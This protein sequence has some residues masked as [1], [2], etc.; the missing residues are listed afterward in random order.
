MA[1]DD[2]R[3]PD[4]KTAEDAWSHLLRETRMPLKD[5][6]LCRLVFFAGMSAALS[7]AYHYGFVN[8]RRDLVA[9]G[10]RFDV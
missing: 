7:I 4:Y 6:E 10:E 8:L 9:L 3:K 1:E 5:Q 2:V